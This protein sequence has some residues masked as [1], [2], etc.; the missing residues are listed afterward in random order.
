MMINTTHRLGNT[1]AREAFLSDDGSGGRYNAAT[2]RATPE[3]TLELVNSRAGF[4]ALDVEWTALFDRAARSI[5]VFQSYNWNWHWANVY[6]ETTPKT[7]LAV[8]VVRKHGRAVAIW[9]LVIERT[10]GLRVLAWMGA[11]VS[12]Y[13]DVLAEDGPGL[14]ATLRDSWAFAVQATRADA[15]RLNKTRADAVVAPL[16]A[17][18]GI[19]I[20][21]YQE[22]PFLDLASAPSWG[23]YDERFAGRG[24][25]KN[26]RRQLRRLEEQGA[27]ALSTWNN[28]ADAREPASRAVAT[29]LAWLEARCLVSPAVADPRF[30]AFFERAAGSDVRQSG[31][32]IASLTCGGVTAAMEIS[33][34]CRDRIAVHV[35]AYGQRFD[36]CGP[37]NLLMEKLLAR[38]HAEGVATYDLLAPGGGYKT[39]WADGAVPVYDHAAGVSIAG[40]VFARGWLGLVRP[41]LKRAIEGLPQGLR[42][43]IRGLFRR[44]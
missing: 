12:Q 26:R 22:A 35:L 24:R 19:P 32:R 14:M 40:T 27:V 13:G 1:A 18:I 21:Q 37:G 34:R 23:A 25:K 8:V 16:L 17:E 38:A 30:R 20:T 2:R 43:R 6:L 3:L 4:N 11:P 31:I 29:K 7:E 5:N 10:L 41:A 9:P 44:G 28:G 39:E 15:I 42:C 33:L 36:K